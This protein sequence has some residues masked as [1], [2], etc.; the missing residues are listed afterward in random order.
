[1]K[2]IVL[3]SHGKFAEGAADTL[4]MVL[5]DIPG[6][7]VI[8]FEM[9]DASTIEG[10]AREL[11]KSIGT[12]DDVYVLTD[13]MGSSVNTAMVNLKKEFPN[14][15]VIAG[16]NFPLILSVAMPMFG[17][18]GDALQAVVDECKSGMI[19]C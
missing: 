19:V 5:G 13:M 17:A 7:H 9:D 1:M 2:Q 15:I 11:L 14:I 8:T 16:V 3:A 10:P 4:K 12:I 6:L 18:K